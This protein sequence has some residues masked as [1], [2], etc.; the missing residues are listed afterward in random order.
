MR[1]DLLWKKRA[2]QDVKKRCEGSRMAAGSRN[3]GENEN[4]GRLCQ[5]VMEATVAIEQGGGLEDQ[6]DRE[7][8]RGE[9]EREDAEREDAERDNARSSS[10]QEREKNFPPSAH[11]KLLDAAEER[12]AESRANVQ[13]SPLPSPFHASAMFQY[14]RSSS[15][16]L[17]LVILVLSL[18]LFSL[19]I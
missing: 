8:E 18:W 16:L 9:G 17:F 15:F 4:S 11:S 7:Q 3:K 13:R 5:T 14:Q 12:E 10:E 6:T 2:E 19:S 1:E